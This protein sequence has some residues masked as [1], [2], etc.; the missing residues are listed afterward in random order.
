[1]KKAKL[2]TPKMFCLH[3][4]FSFLHDR[5][6]VVSMSVETTSASFA[7]NVFLEERERLGVA[8]AQFLEIMYSNSVLIHGMVP[9]RAQDHVDV[10]CCYPELPRVEL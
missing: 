9:H 3:A 7:C 4:R 2:R 10:V 8:L 6:L 5:L 1:M